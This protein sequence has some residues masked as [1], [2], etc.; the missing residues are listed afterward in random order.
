MNDYKYKVIIA[1]NEKLLLN[2]LIKKV[3]KSNLGFKVVAS[4]QDGK[5]ALELIENLIPDLIITDI[6]MPVMDGLELI[7]NISLRLP[8]I[9]KII[10]SDFGEFSYAQ[11]ALKYEVK[12]YL[13]K[14]VKIDT[15][16]E[17][18]NQVSISIDSEK[19]ITNEHIINI[20]HKHSYTPE[21]I[22]KLLQLYLRKN[23]K[24]EINFD[25][26]AQQFNFNSSYL[27]KIFTK[28]IGENPSKYLITLRINE[29]K[30]L[31]L[32][33]KDLKVKEIGQLVGYEDQFYF[34]RLFKNV[35]GKSPIIFR[36]I[37]Y[38]I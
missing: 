18:L 23:Y 10:L 12:A 21:Q 36:N 37:N 8:F 13:L 1:Q 25:N 26:I 15:L 38:T 11:E 6:K 35:T 5:S 17:T 4:A 19:Q 3:E 30:R 14:P 27:S 2:S 29:A 28:Y 9:Q 31:L 22:S 20:K 7:R 24:N 16:T 33:N 34:S 32:N